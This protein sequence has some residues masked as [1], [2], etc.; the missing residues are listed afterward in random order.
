MDKNSVELLL[1]VYHAC[2]VTFDF[3][4]PVLLVVRHCDGDEGRCAAGRV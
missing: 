1:V 3:K 4:L 2:V